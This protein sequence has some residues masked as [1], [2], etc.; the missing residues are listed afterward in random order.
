M[1]T[2]M[3]RKIA[4]GALLGA[5]LVMPAQAAQNAAG[6]MIHATGDVMVAHNGASFVAGSNRAVYPGDVIRT[7]DTGVAQW[8]MGDQ[9]FMAALKN[10]V[11]KLAKINPDGQSLYQLNQGGVRVLSD[12]SGAQVALQ[13]PSGKVQSKGGSDFIAIEC[14][15]NCKKDSGELYPDGLYIKVAAGNVTVSSGSST[16]ASI[17]PAAYLQLADASASLGYS[18][19]MTDV[20]PM[21]VAASGGLAVAAVA[22][23]FV[24]PGQAPVVLS[25]APA[26]FAGANAALS[27][28]VDIRT[29][30]NIR[31][32]LDV[33]GG[34]GGSISPDN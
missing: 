5:C 23:V 7:G 9:V 27:L 17:A 13:S 28:K 4:A 1:Q 21:M 10:S 15:Q 3:M 26:F 18:A 30:G 34:L 22:Y 8:A 2:L 29:S 25:S 11:V 24:A 20:A 16:T 31:A 12:A 6:R 32:F 14:N 33:N 19:S